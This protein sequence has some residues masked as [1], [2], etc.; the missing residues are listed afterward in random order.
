VTE[1]SPGAEAI[2]DGPVRISYAELG[3]EIVRSTRAAM[4]S[5]VEPGDRA[6]IWAPNGY[7]WMIAALGI[8]GAGGVVVPLS[9]RFKGAEAAYALGKA[10]R[11]PH[12]TVTWLAATRSAKARQG[13]DRRGGGR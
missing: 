12:G 3:Q 8:L 6:A 7:R 2:V 13:Q 11:A 9:S 5:G 10:L 1:R 4:A